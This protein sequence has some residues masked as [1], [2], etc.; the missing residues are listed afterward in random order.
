[1]RFSRSIAV[2]CG[3]LVTTGSAFAQVP[4]PSTGNPRFDAVVAKGV[5][6]LKAQLTRRTE[7]LHGGI[8]YLS[9][10]AC[11]KAGVKPNDPAVQAAVHAAKSSAA[12]GVWTPGNKQEHIYEAG[13]AAMLLADANP[14]ANLAEL[15]ALANYL[16][17]QQGTDG[18]WDYPQRKVG[19][20]SMNQYGI[21]GLWSCMR[22]GIKVPPGVWDKC[23]RWH[24][25]K[26]S[27]DGGWAYHPGRQE[28]PGGG[29]S[30]H[31]MTLGAVGTLAICRVIL[32]P[33]YAPGGKK[34][35]PKKKLLFGVLEEVDTSKN[36][37]GEKTVKNPYADYRPQTSA[38]DMNNGL[39]AGLSWINGRWRT[40]SPATGHEFYYYY[41]ME[42]AFA[43]NDIKKMSGQDWFTACGNVLASSQKADGSWTHGHSP[44]IATSFSVLFFMRATKKILGAAYGTGLQLG[45]RGF[46]LDGDPLSKDKKKKK[47]GPLDE[48][49]AR[50]EKMNV[51]G[52]QDVPEEDLS[53]L[54]QKILESDRKELVGQLDLLKKMA[55]NPRGD[56][57]AIVMF[58]LGRSGD[59]RVAP[60]LID[61]LNDPDVG[62]LAE[63]R[64]ALCYISR[65]PRGFGLEPDLAGEV[66]GLPKKEVD[67]IV[68]EWR[69]KAQVKWRRWYTRIRPYDERGDL[70]EIGD[71]GL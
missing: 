64:T 40:D 62:V 60:I 65:K 28:G 17:E 66:E 19:D 43:M 34:N 18:S 12:G 23:A 26:R 10:Y 41:A 33:E 46:D 14:E 7:G 25:Q 67:R 63:A 13:V 54:V 4:E 59:M 15:Q 20:T 71:A 27:G 58:A 51:Q 44:A 35:R 30:T 1:M 56:V 9:G 52:I 24:V 48:M 11:L 42:R 47:L 3:L 32:Y 45:D 57:R 36:Q 49:L 6:Y 50:L 69:Q 29:R 2:A 16:M 55:D 31:N 70:W 22:A 61:A 8:A 68:K 21:L 39:S 38:G 53:D 5:D 37:K